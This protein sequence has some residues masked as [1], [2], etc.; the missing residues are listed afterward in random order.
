MELK[1]KTEA[2][3]RSQDFEKQLEALHQL[4]AR[5]LVNALLP[6]LCSA[7]ELLKWRAVTAIG[8][9]VARLADADAEAARTIVR[10]LIWSLNDESG[11]IG[12]GA[13]EAMGEIMAMHEGMAR[14]YSEILMSYLRE[15]ETSLANPLLV[16]G[17]LWGLGRLGQV[18][19]R[20]LADAVPDVTAWLSSTDPSLRG[21]ALW[22][23]TLVDTRPEVPAQVEAL[24]C[25]ESELHIYLDR[26]LTVRRV[27]ELAS[28][29]AGR[30]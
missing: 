11:A 6:L 15:G 4:P 29:R 2:L 16:R 25:D 21:L 17:V 10:R 30:A 27:C 5:R 12:W 18:R 7:D 14:E 23:L 24:L 22:F 1:R 8:V 19:P 3:L 9:V 28:K 13:P 20:L 26:T